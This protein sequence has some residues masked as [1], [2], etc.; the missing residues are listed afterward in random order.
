MRGVVREDKFVRWPQSQGVSEVI[1]YM[2]II[3]T[4]IPIMQQNTAKFV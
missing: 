2:R 4:E 3:I 1:C